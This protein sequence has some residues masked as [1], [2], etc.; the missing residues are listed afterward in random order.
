M[1]PKHAKP[2]P[3]P[4]RSE[5]LRL[6]LLQTFESAAR[7]LSFTKAG[8]ELFLSQSAVSRQI[9]QL[10]EN[11]GVALFERRQRALALTEAGVVIQRA[12]DESLARLNQAAAR[13]RPVE[14]R[15]EVA[16]TCTPG[17]ASFWLIP[18]LTRFTD[19]RP[20]VDVRISATTDLLDLGRASI[21]VAVRFVPIDSVKGPPLFE[22]ALQPMCAPELANATTRPLRVPADLSR[23]T[24]LT[25]DVPYGELVTV[26]WEPWLRAMDLRDL[27]PANSIQ[28]THY[29][30][31][32][33]AACAGQGVVIG[34]L[35]LLAD[36][37]R[38]GRLVTLFDGLAASRRGYYVE[39]G[40][41]AADNADA[42]DFVRWMAAEA[43]GG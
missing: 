43:G 30:E 4:P 41:R 5:R 17:F 25:I 39:T 32:V 22:E 11:L 34:R 29:V 3:Q 31:A 42:Q 2:D 8:E 12:V 14:A 37:V 38:A 36:L 20:E 6:D 26:D 1:H 9:Q 33:A 16:I 24:L 21:D 23:H 28:F 18:R 19:G 10:E 13:V 7:L 27:K 15:R 35:P 40:P